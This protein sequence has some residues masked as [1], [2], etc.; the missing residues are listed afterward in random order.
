MKIC[1]AEIRRGRV[2]GIRRWERQKKEG[3]EIRRK[4]EGRGRNEI[5]K[6]EG[7]EE[8]EK[9]GRRGKRKE[10]GSREGGTS[11]SIF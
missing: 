2:E 9:E 6:E 3:K 7:K 5:K 11:S 10:G 1:R 8:E 4:E